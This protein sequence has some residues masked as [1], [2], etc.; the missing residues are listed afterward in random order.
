[1]LLFAD[2]MV[3]KESKLKYRRK[4]VI[5]VDLCYFTDDV[6]FCFFSFSPSNRK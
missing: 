6:L 2:H 4:F 5:N 1:M 3:N